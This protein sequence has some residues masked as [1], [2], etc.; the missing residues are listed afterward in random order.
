MSGTWWLEA[1]ENGSDRLDLMSGFSAAYGYTVAAQGFDIQP[2]AE[3]P[4]RYQ[5]L[6]VPLVMK[7]QS[8]N[9]LFNMRRAIL[10]KLNQARAG[11]QAGS[12]LPMVNIAIRFGDADTLVRW[13]V[14]EGELSRGSISSLPGN[15]IGNVQE[16][17]ML[18][19]RCYRGGLGEL[20]QYGPFNVTGAD[21][22]LHVNGVPGDLPA[23]VEVHADDVS[24]GVAVNR[25]RWACRSLPDM[26][27]GD[28][29]AVL[30]FNEDDDEVPDTF[31]G[32]IASISALQTW[33][34]IGSV[35][36]AATVYNGGVFDVYARLRDATA[37][38]GVPG[39]VEATHVA[40]ISLRQSNS[41]RVNSATVE[42]TLDSPPIAGNVLVLL[43]RGA[44]AATITTPAG[45]TASATVVNGT[46]VRA[47][48][49]YRVCDGSES[50]S[51]TVTFGA[52]A[53]HD[54]WVGEFRGISSTSVVDVSATNTNTSATSGTT[55]TTATTSQ[56]NTVSLAF[57]AKSGA[58]VAT[59]TTALGFSS[60]LGNQGVGVSFR[61][62]ST[63]ATQSSSA[64]SSPLTSQSWANLILVLAGA[65]PEPSTV[66]ANGY[67]VRIVAESAIGGLSTSS[68]PATITLTGVGAIYTE[69]TAASGPVS[70][71]RVYV[72]A[73]NGDWIYFNTGSTATN[74]TITDL[75]DANATEDPPANTTISAGTFRL[76]IGRTNSATT[77]PPIGP[78]SA[79]IG[80][81]EWE[82]VYAGRVTLPPSST[83][84]V[85]SAP[86][87]TIT[88]QGRAD[89]TTQLDA[90]AI[91]LLPAD[92]NNT[93][94]ACYTPNNLTSGL[95]WIAWQTVGGYSNG[96]L[97]DGSDEAGNLNVRGTLAIG[98][99]DSTLAMIPTVAG[100]VHN[101]EDVE[102]TVTLNCR[103]RYLWL[104]GTA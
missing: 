55:G 6:S 42:V 7:G 98:P 16:P 102:M 72:R 27:A 62:N 15:V 20:T 97:R 104:A 64:S 22:T 23:L 103:A 75:G 17:A 79:A 73:D 51:V 70:Q 38:L 65:Q 59:P 29:E 37:A 13:F 24:D 67:T 31:T 61:I 76:F 91:I 45:F 60:L 35:S 77:Q 18:T 68:S 89:T 46:S 80:N 101:V 57:F 32:G 54:V 19:L 63:T 88:L 39:G 53:I 33:Q 83:P 44:N 30:P 82:V 26:S 99:G 56:N 96:F 10:T 69:W 49:F 87:F 9:A 14:E 78:F 58:G 11:A 28:F 5:I 84:N 52:A 48:S 86:G 8:K 92:E 81:S 94:D 36:R 25:L 100:G 95:E 71:Y 85:A 12:G 47:A 4:D 3:D 66:P 93:V 40:G 41:G 90:D 50:A 43:A 21:P 34:T 1:G 2:D 74:Y